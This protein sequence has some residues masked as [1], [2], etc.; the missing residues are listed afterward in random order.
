MSFNFLI[1]FLVKQ[2]IKSQKY[3]SAPTNVIW[4]AYRFLGMTSKV[5]NFKY[6]FVYKY[7]TLN[8]WS[9]L[10]YNWVMK[11]TYNAHLSDRG[12]GTDEFSLKNCCYQWFGQPMGSLKHPGLKYVDQH[13]EK[14]EPFF[15]FWAILRQKIGHYSNPMLSSWDL[16]SQHSQWH[17][18]SSHTRR[19]FLYH[20]Q[21]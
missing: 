19:T 21:K 16:S 15:C 6:L 13:S 18:W 4:Q 5:N 17:L 2:I 20:Q 1:S 12:N 9:I 7:C 14:L 3:I 8:Q 10:H 11:S